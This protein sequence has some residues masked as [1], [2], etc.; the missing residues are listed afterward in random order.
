MQKITFEQYSADPRYICCFM[1]Q[2]ADGL[3]DAVG[4]RDHIWDIVVS[5]SQ[6]RNK[7]D[8]WDDLMQ[9]CESN[10]YI[11]TTIDYQVV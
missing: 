5:A 10:G 7:N 9:I 1:Y 3:W 4:F 8:A 6:Y 11:P 2:T